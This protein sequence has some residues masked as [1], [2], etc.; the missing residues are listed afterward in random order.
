MSRLKKMF[1][2]LK[3]IWAA[4]ENLVPSEIP[5]TSPDTRTVPDDFEHDE[6][7]LSSISFDLC[8]PD[9]SPCML[10]KKPVEFIDT[11]AAALSG[12]VSTIQ[13]AEELLDDCKSE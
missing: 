3:K 12:P 5:D 9:D 1:S 10:C 7:N 11:V 13:L 2:Q 6:N 8:D 4:G